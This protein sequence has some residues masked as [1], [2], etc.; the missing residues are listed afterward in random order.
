MYSL[1]RRMFWCLFTRAAAPLTLRGG[2]ESCSIWWASLD[3]K[4]KTHTNK[5]NTNNTKQYNK[6]KKQNKTKNQNLF[7]KKIIKQKTNKLNKHTHTHKNKQQQQQQQQQ[8]KK[9]KQYNK[10]KIKQTKQTQA[11]QN[12]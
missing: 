10:T 3:K 9:K 5:I 7:K 12:N 6:T 2:P 1:V 8:Q 4:T 11:K